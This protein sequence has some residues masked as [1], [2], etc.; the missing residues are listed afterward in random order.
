MS[1]PPTLFSRLDTPTRAMAAGVLLALSMPP[2]GLYPLA[3]I[4]LVPLLV[5]WERLQHGWTLFREAYVAFLFMAVGAGF[6]ALFHESMRAALFAGLGLLLLPLPHAAAFALSTLVRR[7]FGVPAGLLALACNV[8]AAEYLVAHLPGGFPWLLLSHTQ[9]AALDFNQFADLG[10]VGL[11]SLFVL[12]TNALGY[13]FVRAAPRPG[14]LPGWRTL[15]FLLFFVLLSGAAVYGEERRVRLAVP[16][17]ELRV[18]VV[19]PAEPARVWGDATD[20]RRVE[21]L[22]A[23]SDRHLR[24]DTAASAVRPVADALRASQAPQPRRLLV[25]PE[26]ALPPL[27]APDAQARL[28]NRLARWSGDRQT[29][30]LTGALTQPGPGA[31]FYNAALFIR[32]GAPPQEYAKVHLTP[33]VEHIPFLDGSPL[34]DAMTLPVEGAHLGSGSAPVLLQGNGYRVGAV[35]GH[36]SL[37]GD[38]VRRFVGE[39]ADLLVT[40]AEAGWWGRAAGARQHLDL[41]RLRA[42]ETR[43]AVVMA[44]VSGTSAVIS[45]DGRVEPLAGWMEE[46]VAERLVPL[47]PDLTFYTRHGDWPG[48]FALWGTAWFALVL[49]VAAVFF[50]QPGPRKRARD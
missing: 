8:L 29:A 37:R 21:R 27:P 47:Q 30:L 40:L 45:P 10:G 38:Y 33:L 14:F 15:L 6:W 36:E 39:G 2:L 7:R 22:A 25:W 31:P 41:T 42:I 44:T 46:E 32:Q 20:W 24:D 28:Y 4:A 17:A 49:G 9:A 35:I 11:L 5:R 16:R 19:Q 50:R 18:A 43:R 48:R 23:L 26:A 13:A 34:L 12:T 3:W 1:S